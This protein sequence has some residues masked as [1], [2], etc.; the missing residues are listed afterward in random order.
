MQ[1]VTI[2]DLVTSDRGTFLAFDLR[3]LLTLALDQVMDSTWICDHVECMGRC[4][5]EVHAASEDD[6][7]QAAR[8]FRQAVQV[9][10]ES[11]QPGPVVTARIATEQDDSDAD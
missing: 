1:A 3:D 5:D 4:A 6:W 9:K 8:A 10:Q 2:H 7:E 11:C